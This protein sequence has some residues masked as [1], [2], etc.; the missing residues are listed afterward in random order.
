MKNDNQFEAATACA[1]MLASAE[2]VI[3]EADRL[4]DDRDEFLRARPMLWPTSGGRNPAMNRTPLVECVLLE[5]ADIAAM[6]GVSK[7]TVRRMRD[8]GR[9]PAS[10]RLSSRQKEK[11]PRSTIETWIAAGCPHVGEADAARE[12]E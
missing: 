2:A 5:C 11:W 9:M 4:R 7:Q 10:F 8:A 6:L 3:R 12:G 1:R